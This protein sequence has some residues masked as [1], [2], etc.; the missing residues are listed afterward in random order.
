MMRKEVD[1]RRGIAPPKMTLADAANIR[2]AWKA[3]GDT[4]PCG[5]FNL[6][7]LT[8]SDGNVLDLDYVCLTCGQ[9]IHVD[10]TP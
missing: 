5:H 1:A 3:L 10:R 6:V 8:D 4:H 7:R 2:A 9:L